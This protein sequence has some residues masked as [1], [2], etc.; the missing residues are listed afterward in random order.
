MGN[1]QHTILRFGS[2]FEFEEMRLRKLGYR[3]EW[4]CTYDGGYP[5]DLVWSNKLNGW[6]MRRAIKA[7]CEKHG[8]VDY[9]IVRNRGYQHDLRGDAVY[10]LWVSSNTG[11]QVRRESN[12]GNE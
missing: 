5:S 3:Q 10:E 1:N 7:W 9:R 2:T 12:G 4:A 8:V 11:R 6:E